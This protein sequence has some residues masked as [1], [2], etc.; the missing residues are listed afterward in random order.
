MPYAK[1]ESFHI[2][3]GWLSKGM[4][5]IQENGRALREDNAPM[6]LGIGRN[7]VYALRFWLLAT[8]LTRQKWVG[9]LEQEL[10]E[11]GELVWRYD[12]YLEDEGTLWLIHY[13]LA[14]SV[15]QATAWYWFFNHFAYNTFDQD[16][17]V[18][19]LGQW[20]I[21]HEDREAIA[22]ST[23]ER[24]FQVLVRTYL[25]STRKRSPEN[26]LECPLTE[27]GLLESIDGDRY[28]RVP[29]TPSR[30]HPIVPLFVLLQQEPEVPREVPQVGL[31]QA[32]REPMGVGAVFNLG[33]AGLIDVVNR[34][35][36][37]YQDL[38]VHLVRTAGLDQ[39]TL[40]TIAPF[41]L[42]MYYYKERER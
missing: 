23:L 39:L 32:L 34:L 3:E 41:E 15:D 36:R 25:P 38:A 16:V 42:L 30:L 26:L 4:R 40:P 10:S 37:N 2:R 21:S 20:A 18:E 7:M 8:G 27:L 14:C 11:F 33:P 9:Q 24:D 29:L 12:R 17:F 28:R 6:Q 13:H 19:E 31:T 35:E 1:H 5:A 22:Q